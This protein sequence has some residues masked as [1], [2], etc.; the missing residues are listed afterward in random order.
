MVALVGLGD[1]FVDL[2]HRDLR[3]NAVAFSDRQ[4]DG[5][6][7]GVHALHHLAIDAFKLF[8]SGPLA[9]A[10]FLRRLDQSQN[11]LRDQQSLRVVALCGAF[12][13]LLALPIAGATVNFL[14]ADC[15]CTCHD[16]ISFVF[17]LL[18]PC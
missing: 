15:R 7:H 10:P 2:A 9:Q 18:E 17:K 5:I 14:F 6:E 4:Q 16:F 8:Q 13:G 3:Q 1:Q 11:L 12:A